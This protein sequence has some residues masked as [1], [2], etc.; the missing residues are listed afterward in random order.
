MIAVTGVDVLR[1]A[2]EAHARLAA[3]VPEAADAAGFPALVFLRTGDVA[4]CRIESIGP[5]SL[6]L[7]TPAAADSATP[8]EVPTAVVQAVE[9]VPAAAS[10][11]ID[12]TRLD[13]LLTLPRGQRFRPPTHLLRLTDGDYLRGRNVS[14]AGDQVT[15]ELQTAVKRLPRETVAR[16]IWLHPEDEE[17]APGEA[18]EPAA[19]QVERPELGSGLLL[20]GVAADGRRMTLTADSLSGNLVRGRSAAFGAVR[21]DLGDVDRLLIGGAIDADDAERPYSRWKLRPAAEPRALQGGPA[22]GPS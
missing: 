20:Q 1:E 9:L 12:R 18:P 21:L 2:L 19:I 13:R 6:R 11:S 4:P 8:L 14:V 10:R 15:I 22:A 17:T 7:V 16:V 5:Q 3:P